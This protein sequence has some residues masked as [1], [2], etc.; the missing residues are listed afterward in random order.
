MI[1]RPDQNAP[2]VAWLFYVFERVAPILAAHDAEFAKLVEDN[3]VITSM[4]QQEVEQPGALLASAPPNVELGDIV[5][6]VVGEFAGLLARAQAVRDIIGTQEL[7]DAINAAFA[8]DAMPRGWGWWLGGPAPKE[9]KDGA[10]FAPGGNIE[11]IYQEEYAL[12]RLAKTGLTPA[13]VEQE[14][15][16]E[17]GVQNI[18]RNAGIGLFQTSHFDSETVE[19]TPGP[20]MGYREM[21][22]D[23]AGITEAAG[24]GLF[25]SNVIV[26]DDKDDEGT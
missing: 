17:E 22:A 12:R 1:D 18:M 16:G 23:A 24:L 11:P 3:E 13:Q 7:Y 2:R 21:H 19:R 5:D 9:Q 20:P 8:P 10:Y 25:Q 14:V 4:I 26:D 6:L 15:R